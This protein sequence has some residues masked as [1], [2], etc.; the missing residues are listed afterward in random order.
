MSQEL[1]DRFEREAMPDR[2][3]P[4]DYL[5]VP[6]IMGRTV[7]VP[8]AVTVV[9]VLIGATLLGL[10]GALVAIPAAAPIRLVLQEVTFRRMDRS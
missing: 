4:E 7:Q 1:A 10:V 3:M 9:A 8:A 5:L 2:G 6:R